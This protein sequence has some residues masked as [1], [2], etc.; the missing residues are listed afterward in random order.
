MRTKGIISLIAVLLLCLPS[1]AGGFALLYNLLAHRP[2]GD[3]SVA[4]SVSVALAMLFGTPLV[5]LATGVCAIVLFRMKV[6]P[7]IKFADVAILSLGMI[8][9]LVVSFRFRI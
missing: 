3:W 1:F 5:I 2:I 7:R 6:P 9:T 4:S 8:A